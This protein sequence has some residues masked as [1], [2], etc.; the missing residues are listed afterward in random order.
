MFRA[1]HVVEALEPRRLLSGGTSLDVPA[2]SSLPG[3]YLKMY[4]DFDGHAGGWGSPIG[5][6]E[7]RNAATPAYDIDGDPTNFSDEELGNIRQIHQIVAEKYSPFE[8]DI[9][10]IDPGALNDGRAGKIVIGGDGVWYN[11]W[12]SSGRGA[13]GVA[14]GDG[15]WG[16]LENI[17]FM[18]DSP[19]NVRYIAEGAAHE[20]GHMLGLA[21]QSEVTGGVVTVQYLPGAIMGRGDLGSS[22]GRWRYGITSGVD[23]FDGSIDVGGYQ[24]DYGVLVGKG[25]PVRADD[26]GDDRA[27]ATVM[28]TSSS[29]FSSKGVIEEEADIDYFR[30]GSVLPGTAFTVRVDVDSLAPMLDPQ[31]ALYDAAGTLV[32]SAFTSSYGE[33]IFVSSSVSSVYYLAVKPGDV[34]GDNHNIGSYSV[35]MERV[36][37]NDD[38]P[39][40]ATRISGVDGQFSHEWTYGRHQVTGF[41]SSDDEW[42][43]YKFAMTDLWHG[44]SMRASLTN[45]SSNA[46]LYLLREVGWNGA[47]EIGTDDELDAGTNSGTSSEVVTAPTNRYNDFYLAVRHRGGA[48]TGYTLTLAIDANEP[49]HPAPIGSQA[50]Y[51]TYGFVSSGD[52]DA[53]VGRSTWANGLAYTTV[54]LEFEPYL[55]AATFVL[56][57]DAD[58]NGLLEGA[59]ISNTYIQGGGTTLE[60]DNVRGRSPAGDVLLVNIRPFG[61]GLPNYRFKYQVDAMPTLDG[62][63]LHEV[64]TSLLGLSPSAHAAIIGELVLDEDDDTDVLSLGRP[65]PGTVELRMTPHVLDSAKF[66]LIR[67]VNQNGKIDQGEVLGEADKF[68]FEVDEGDPSLYYLISQFVPG[69]NET[70]HYDILYRDGLVTDPSGQNLQN[71]R[72]LPKGL[73]GSAT[74]YAAWSNHPLLDRRTV[75]HSLVIEQAGAL[76]LSLIPDLPRQGAGAADEG[77]AAGLMVIRDFNNN[78]QIDPDERL[79][80]Y[81]GRDA[82]DALAVNAEPGTYFIGVYVPQ[83]ELQYDPT[84]L[85][86][87]RLEWNLA[88]PT[89][90]E[91]VKVEGA[92]F[93]FEQAPLSVIVKFTEDVEMTLG[94]G[95][96]IL[97]LLTPNGPINV[98]FIGEFY[99][100]AAHA[101]FLGMETKSPDGNYRLTI[102]AQSVADPAGNR[103]EEDFV[104]D[105]YILA[106]D[107]NRDRKVDFFDFL[108]LR[109]NYGKSDKLFSEGDFN[110]DRQVD[111]FDFLIL[112]GNYNVTLP[113]PGGGGSLFADGKEG[114]GGSRG[115]SGGRDVL[116]R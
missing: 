49:I 42:D 55:T 50:E 73:T 9:T 7:D 33:S 110:Y 89:D 24:N 66:T 112:R 48:G 94:T 26:H 111:F 52:V 5:D 27:S 90:K 36:E 97:E 82:V 3:A 35:A 99:D 11:T 80:G 63:L 4:L 115:G 17:G 45:L 28:S 101:L 81:A 88:E 10:T 105:F 47:I 100:P 31:L 34:T 98:P 15:F 75:F 6:V 19:E 13:G 44:S 103:L 1:F 39:A 96:V 62:S 8:I 87:Y 30:F 95:D 64:G 70:V 74:G 43:W 37:A 65:A 18:W 23:S 67:D 108:I 79:A 58:G 86:D 61:S 69:K 21:H 57:Y 59:E 93:R 41:V 109:S 40:T 12:G 104:H 16:W 68:T 77:P 32:E 29:G 76:Q 71:A 114:S 20:A 78:G 106:G 83:G 53:F 22:G 84:H 54:D 51:E 60:L 25:V 14:Q 85:F 38:T 56:G 46:D 102:R 92:Q 113:P 72:S 2:L 91:P 107:A 116:P